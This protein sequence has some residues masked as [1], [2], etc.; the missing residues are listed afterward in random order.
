MIDSKLVNNTRYYENEFDDVIVK[1]LVVDR[2]KYFSKVL[3][4]Y[5]RMRENVFDDENTDLTK[6]KSLLENI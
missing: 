1:K 6:L 2:I 4:K 3:L 5:L